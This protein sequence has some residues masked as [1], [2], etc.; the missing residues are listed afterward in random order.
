MIRIRA[1]DPAAVELAV[2][3][4]REPRPDALRG[5]FAGV[6][7]FFHSRLGRSGPADQRACRRVK[8]DFFTPCRLFIIHS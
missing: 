6:L 5:G 3:S 1:A 8:V 4:P 7:R 2:D